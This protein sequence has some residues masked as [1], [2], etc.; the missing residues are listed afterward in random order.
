MTCITVASGKGGV[1]KTFMAV[2]LALGFA[3]LDKKVLLV[4]ADLGLANADIVLGI[5]PRYTLQDALFQGLELG[6]VVASTPFGIDLLAASSGSKE[7]T[8]LGEARMTIFI[9]ELVSFAAKY[10]VLLFDCAA[11]I[12]SSV[13]SF[14]AAAPQ[15]LVVATPHPTSIMDVYALLKVIH[16]DNLA[17]NVGFVL[18]Q[19]DN[20]KHAEKVKNNLLGVIE[21]YLALKVEFLGMIP[22]SSQV[23]KA[24]HSRKPLMALDEEDPA[25]HK[26]FEI[27]RAI[28]QKQGNIR[29]AGLNAA[30]LLDGM[31]KR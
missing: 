22:F 13:T 5:N 11:G 31:L 23:S 15:N 10:D 16:Q 12:N 29:L 14:I 8:S 6:E 18:N 27:A 20:E 3:R 21:K 9:E 2:N 4:D 17:Q 26:V 25:S 1:G 7:M 19:V 28:L 24:V 30:G